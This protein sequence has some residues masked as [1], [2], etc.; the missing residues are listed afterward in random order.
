VTTLVCNAGVLRPAGPLWEVEPE[1]WWRTQEIHLRGAFLY[2]NAFVPGMVERGGGRVIVVSTSGGGKTWPYNS[3]YVVSKHALTMLADHLAQEARSHNVF[4]WAI[5]PAGTPTEL[6]RERLGDPVAERYM[7]EAIAAQRASFGAADVG[8]R[9]A[10]N[11]QF[12]VDLASGR[13]DLLSGRY[14]RVDDDLAAMV[15]EQAGAVD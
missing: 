14:L 11:A 8:E 6:V 3:A 15:R 13:W 2:I 10:R 7:A 12:C 9:I 5:A 4:A 1:I